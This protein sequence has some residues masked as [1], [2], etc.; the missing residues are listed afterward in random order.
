MMRC[1]QARE[2]WQGPRL[3]HAGSVTKARGEVG[4][5]EGVMCKSAEIVWSS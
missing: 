1:R 4:E 5:D 2:E 3:V